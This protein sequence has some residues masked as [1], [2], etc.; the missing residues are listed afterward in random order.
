MRLLH[1]FRD[2]PVVLLVVVVAGLGAWIVS[3]LTLSRQTPSSGPPPQFPP[4]SLAAD[5]ATMTLPDRSP[6]RVVSAVPR[7]KIPHLK[8]GMSR[9][10]VEDL[11]GAPHPEQLG[12]IRVEQDGIATYQTVYT[13]DLD[14]LPQNTIKPRLLP[15][16]P[17][18][19]TTTE[20]VLTLIFDASRPGHP[21]LRVKLPD[22]PL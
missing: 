12:P 11:L 13:I 7:D 19:Q 10:A 22:T 14:P 15:P 5:Q 17:L 8:P 6:V 4:F 2:R 16:R 18:G 1:W 20:P 3:D 21:L 9:V